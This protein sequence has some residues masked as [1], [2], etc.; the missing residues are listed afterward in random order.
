MLHYHPLQTQET[1]Q[2]V[3]IKDIT[4]G[5]GKSSVQT[6]PK[7]FRACQVTANT[8]ALVSYQYAAGSSSQHEAALCKGAASF[9]SSHFSLQVGSRSSSMQR[10]LKQSHPLI[11]MTIMT[12]CFHTDSLVHN[13]N[14]NACFAVVLFECLLMWAD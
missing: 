4:Q 1:L 5:E 2:S 13:L 9:G 10:T 14:P 8:L 12:S 6:D 11:T 7:Q 3:A